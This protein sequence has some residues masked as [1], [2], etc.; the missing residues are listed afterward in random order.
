M[1][2]AL[3]FGGEDRGLRRLSRELCDDLVVVPMSGHVESLNISVA[4]GIALYECWGQKGHK[5]N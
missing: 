4:V 2:V 1:G 3:V 5:K